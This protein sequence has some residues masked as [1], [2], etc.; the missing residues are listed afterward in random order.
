MAQCASPIQLF[1]DMER[2]M[3]AWIVPIPSTPDEA[4]VWSQIALVWFAAN[5]RGKEEPVGRQALQSIDNTKRRAWFHQTLGTGVVA[6]AIV[7][8]LPGRSASHVWPR[9][10]LAVLTFCLLAVEPWVRVRMGS[11]PTL[12]KYFA[13]WEVLLNVSF[14]ASVGILIAATHLTVVEP[15]ISLPLRTGQL[16]A[17]TIALAAVLFMFGGA[18][19]IVRGVLDKANALPLLPGQTGV[20]APPSTTVPAP[21]A[22]HLP[23]SVSSS[24]SSTTPSSST[25]PSS[26]SSADDDDDDDPDDDPSVAADTKPRVAGKIDI[27]E[28]NRGRTIGNLERLVMLAIVGLGNYE[29]L[30]FIVAAKGLIRAPEFRDRDFAEYFIVGSLSSVAVA[31]LV[32]ASLRPLVLFLWKL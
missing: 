28:Y 25:A 9:L 3:T 2:T 12:S 19:H 7:A 11:S 26:S 10:A 20:A 22:V 21:V 15:L 5:H 32:G 30:G 1:G 14:L 18:T 13:E 6:A 16:A 4:L 31:L 27:P 24:P 17:V 29:A 23:A 8:A